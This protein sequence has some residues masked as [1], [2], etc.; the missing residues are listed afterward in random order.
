MGGYTL[1]NIAICDTD[2]IYAD[3]LRHILEN[4][5]EVHLMKVDVK[6]F[7][8]TDTFMKSDLSQWSL[9]FIETVMDHNHNG[10]A[11]ARVIREYNQHATIIFM[12]TKNESAYEAFEVSAF[13]Y[14]MKPVSEKKLYEALEKFIEI[15]LQNHQE[16]LCIRQGKNNFKI[17]YHKILYIET[18]DRKIKIA[19][20]KKN[21][22]VNESIS[23]LEKKL[24]DKR[25]YRIH[26]SYIV[27]MEHIEE[28][29][30]LSLLLANGEKAYIS[31]LRFKEFN[32]AFK[33]Y[34]EI[35]N[36]FIL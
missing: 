32:E 30:G 24:A 18:S 4:F 36:N 5:F 10:I 23:E 22:Y 2:R 17:M 31:R 34:N 1:I 3:N 25:F 8:L 7:A 28:Q 6:W 21:Y 9:I 27:N 15:R 11:I 29:N 12:S 20:R 16:F 14:L 26:K 35:K 13:R 19:T 33:K